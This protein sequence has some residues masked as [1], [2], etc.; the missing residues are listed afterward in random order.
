MSPDIRLFRASEKE[1]V[2]LVGTSKGDQISHTFLRPD[3]GIV[4][5]ILPHPAI[6]MR[7][8]QGELQEV[9]DSQGVGLYELRERLNQ[10][11]VIT[12]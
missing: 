12:F 8:D 7:A 2:Y 11:E 5:P 10:G 6:Q 4:N 1:T 3:R 9:A